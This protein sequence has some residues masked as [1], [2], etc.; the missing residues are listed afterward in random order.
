MRA[1][2]V[3]VIDEDGGQ[4]GIMHPLAALDLARQ[5]GLDLVEVAPNSVPPV[6]RLL[7]W[8]RFRYEQTKRER[9]SRKAQKAI[10]VKEVRFDPRWGMVGEHDLMTKANNVKRFLEAGDK[11]KLTVRFRGRAVVHPEVGG[12]MLD[13]VMEH[14][15]E[16]AVVEQAPRL[17]GRTLT[18]VIAPRPGVR[19]A[20]PA[21][22]QPPAPEPVTQPQEET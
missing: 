2:E 15:G 14:V 11:V 17:E 9:E 5:R 20:A 12:K 21:G 16:L 7:D 19:R 3:R 13:Q 8:G 4:L 18:S 6:C 1:R 22:E 10:T